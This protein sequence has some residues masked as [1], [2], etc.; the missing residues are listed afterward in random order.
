[1]D[2]KISIYQIAIDCTSNKKKEINKNGDSFRYKDTLYVSIDENN[3]LLIS[4]TPDIL[5]K[6]GVCQCIMIHIHERKEVSNWYSWYTIQFIDKDGCVHTNKLDERFKLHVNYISHFWNQWMYLIFDGKCI[7]SL[8]W[9]NEDKLQ[10]VWNLY[11]KCKSCDTHREAELLG[12]LAKRDMSVLSLTSDLADLN[13]TA[14]LLKQERDM[15]KSL[16]DD[17]KNLIKDKK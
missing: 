4:E 13:Y 10:D 9:P 15:Y 2:N 14:E 11:I 7:F 12:E 6:E 16:L 8:K 3:E 1:M 5:K 17:V